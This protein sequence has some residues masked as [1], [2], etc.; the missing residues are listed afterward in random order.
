MVCS[1][2]GGFGRKPML[3]NALGRVESRLGNGKRASRVWARKTN[4]G[5]NC[6]AH[7][8]E[9]LSNT[10]A[11]R[12]DIWSECQDRHL[13]AGVIGAAPGRIAAMV[14]GDDDEIVRP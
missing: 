6:R 2:P 3:S 5:C 10:D 8:G 1:T 9:A 4:M 13:L 7:I 14:R 11:S 12:A